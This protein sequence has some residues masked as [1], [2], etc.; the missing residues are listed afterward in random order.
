MSKPG[1]PLGARQR[2][3]LT[4]LADMER[5]EI[6]PIEMMLRVYN[7]SIDAY[8][9]ARGYSDKSDAGT[10]YLSVAGQ[11]A[12]QLARFR[13]PTL[14]A[15]AVKDIGG[16]DGDKPAMTTEEAMRIIQS[17]PFHPK[18]I[19]TPRVVEAMTSNIQKPVLPIGGK[20]KE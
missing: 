9:K 18:A 19:E 10:G 1:R 4:A 11:M 16:G 5:L 17:D 15:I 3:T 13:H 6:N 2:G 8:E 14:S 12:S 7:L 20:E